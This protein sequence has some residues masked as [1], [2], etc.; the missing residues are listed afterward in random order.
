MGLN[1]VGKVIL[2][3]CHMTEEQSTSLFKTISLSTNIHHL[4]LSLIS[5]EHVPVK[6]ISQGA[7]NL[8]TLRVVDSD[9][10]KEQIEEILILVSS[11]TKLKLLEVSFEDAFIICDEVIEKSELKELRVSEEYEYDEE[12]WM[13][14]YFH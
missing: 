8:E 12:N 14:F 4:D 2:A 11:D 1:K 7:V 9:L 6:V 10:L 13:Q 3:D 5:L